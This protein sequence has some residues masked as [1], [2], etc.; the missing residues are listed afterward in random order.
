MIFALLGLL[1]HAGFVCLQHLIPFS[2]CFRSLARRSARAYV[3]CRLWGTCSRFGCCSTR[4]SSPCHHCG[5]LGRCCSWFPTFLRCWVRAA[6][7]AGT[8]TRF[9]LLSSVTFHEHNVGWRKG[10]AF[11]CVGSSVVAECVSC[12]HLLNFEMTLKLRL[13]VFP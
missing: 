10:S 8:H 6:S 9:H 2:H 4:F 3:C 5:T 12:P 13:G 7:A 11:L 1:G